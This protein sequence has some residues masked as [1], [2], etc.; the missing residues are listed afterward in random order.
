MGFALDAAFIVLTAEARGSG[1]TNGIFYAGF[2]NWK[3]EAV[4]TRK[5]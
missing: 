1:S 5:I 3:S 2:S 4:L